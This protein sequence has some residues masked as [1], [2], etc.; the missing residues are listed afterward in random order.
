Q[1]VVIGSGATAVTL[2]PAMA[3]AAGHVTMLQRTPSYVMPVPRGDRWAVR[4]APLVGRRRGH[5]LTRR[6]NIVRQQAIWRFCQR[7]PKLARRLIRH[8]NVKLLPPGYPV[9]EHFSPP[10]GPWDQ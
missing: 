1:V 5:A 3:Q 9:D 8:F 2:V 4:L 6:K 7:H 10:Y